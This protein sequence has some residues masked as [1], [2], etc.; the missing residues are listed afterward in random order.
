LRITVFLDAPSNAEAK[1]DAS[2]ARPLL[3]NCP[4]NHCLCEAKDSAEKLHK[5]PGVMKSVLKRSVFL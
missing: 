5:I 4:L 1:T 3:D 2:T